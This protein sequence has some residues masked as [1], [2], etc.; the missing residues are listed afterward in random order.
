MIGRE[1]YCNRSFRARRL[2]EKDQVDSG[3]TFRPLAYLWRS[4]WLKGMQLLLTDLS[5]L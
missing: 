1:E 3:M 2:P 4:N 5:G